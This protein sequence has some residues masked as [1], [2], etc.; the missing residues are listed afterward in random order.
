MET[1]DFMQEQMRNLKWKAVFSKKVNEFQVD[2]LEFYKSLHSSKE[3]VMDGLHSI[4]SS[5]MQILAHKTDRYLREHGIRANIIVIAPHFK[6]LIG[7][8]V[9]HFKEIPIIY[10][11]NLCSVVKTE[12]AILV[13]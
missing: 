1:S 10:S 6:F 12:D 7:K 11:L 8:H 5:L 13:F 2:A 9:T 4:K 3:N